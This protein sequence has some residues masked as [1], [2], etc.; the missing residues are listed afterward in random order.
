MPRIMRLPGTRGAVQVFDLRELL[1]DARRVDEMTQAEAAAALVKLAS[2]QAAVAA[3]L[4]AAP[5]SALM[6]ATPPENDRLLTAEDLAKRFGRSLDWV[7][8]QAKHWPF[9]R[10]L[11]RRT[12]RFSEAGMLRWLGARQG[13]NPGGSGGIVGASDSARKD[14]HAARSGH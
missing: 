5:G 4:R 11:T 10:R 7:Y 6:E 9:T 13:V 12:M 2:L 14:S 8:R 1:G 3:R